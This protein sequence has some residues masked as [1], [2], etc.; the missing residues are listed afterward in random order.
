[1]RGSTGSHT[2]STSENYIFALSAETSH[3]PCDL[4]GFR[5]AF[6]NGARALSSVAEPTFFDHLPEAALAQSLPFTLMLVKRFIS[7]GPKMYNSSWVN[8]LQP[9]TRHLAPRGMRAVIH[10]GSTHLVAEGDTQ[11]LL[12][13]CTRAI[14]S[15][16]RL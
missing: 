7:V 9:R 10:P 2:P 12:E 1:M 5:A 11:R 16:W 6:H 8:G 13:P 15:R 14:N 4:S 3:D